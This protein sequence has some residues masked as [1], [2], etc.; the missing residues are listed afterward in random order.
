MELRKLDSR[1]KVVVDLLN[2]YGCLTGEDMRRMGI[3][4]F[5]IDMGAATYRSIASNLER[6][7][8]CGSSRNEHNKKVFWLIKED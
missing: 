3:K 2:K 7:G 8:I 4:D 6:K 5:G 1:T